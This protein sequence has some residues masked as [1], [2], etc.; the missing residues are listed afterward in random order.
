MKKSDFDIYFKN[1]FATSN[2][3]KFESWFASLAAR[4]YGTDFEPIKAGG[5]NG[6][7][8]SDGRI[9]SSET[10]FQCYAPE[11]PSTFAKNA[12]SKISD[13]FPEV[14]EYWPNLKEWVFVHNNK[15]GIPTSASDVLENLRALYPNIKIS[16]AT[17]NF[18]KDG[19]HDKLTLQ[20]LIDI[21]PSASLDFREVQMSHIRPLLK[22]IIEARKASHFLNN[23]GDIPDEKKL[24]FNS[25]SPDSKFDITRARPHVDVVDRHI[26]RMSVP[27]NASIIQN[28]M[29]NK[30]IECKDLGYDPDEIL[31]QLLNFCG[32]DGT[33]TDRNAAYVIVAY[34]F[35]SCDIFENMPSEPPC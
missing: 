16:T 30:Y 11:S 20:Q 5:R 26:A 31:K 14:V 6:D 34:F 19:L 8:K 10:V 25:L 23:F 33:S 3:S 13:S 28:E 7:K 9:I 1:A 35:D 18:L 17:R 12:A 21:Y 15:D 24:D 32:G 22:K 27:Q 2:Q 29:Q 4:V